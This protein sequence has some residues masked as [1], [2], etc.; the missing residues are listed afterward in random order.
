MNDHGDLVTRLPARPG[1][2]KAAI[3]VLHGAKDPVVPK[4]HRDLFEAEMEC[5][6][7]VKWQML[8]F[9]GLLH[10]FSEP[11]SDVPGIARYDAEAARQACNMI[12]DFAAAAFEGK[13]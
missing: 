7:G 9:G 2:I 1:D 3:C 11:E 5:A 6:G 13:I 8:V 10:S 4:E 12:H